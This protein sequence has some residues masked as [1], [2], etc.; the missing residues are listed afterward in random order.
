MR[1]AGRRVVGQC[2]FAAGDL[3][4]RVARDDGDRLVIAVVV[5]GKRGSGTKDAIPA[6]QAM[7]SETSGE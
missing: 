1:N 6:T 3:A 2:V 5:T 7:C 4:Y